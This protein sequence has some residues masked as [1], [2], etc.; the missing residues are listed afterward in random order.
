MI[1]GKKNGTGE[2]II[3]DAAGNYKKPDGKCVHH[4]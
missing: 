3:S 1:E 4:R 2:I